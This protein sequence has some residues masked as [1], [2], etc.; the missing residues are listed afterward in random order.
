M[1]NVKKCIRRIRLPRTICFAIRELT[2]ARISNP[3]IGIIIL[4]LHKLR[5]I[6]VIAI[7]TW[8]LFHIN[9]RD[10]SCANVY[11]RSHPTAAENFAMTICVIPI[12]A[13]SNI[14]RINTYVISIKP[15]DQIHIH[16]FFY[17]VGLVVVNNTCEALPPTSHISFKNLNSSHKAKSHL[18]KKT[19]WTIPLQLLLLENDLNQ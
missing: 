11:L 12:R 8:I 5:M 1:L 3:G 6:S 7:R 4:C 9:A 15:A 14:T 13:K 17:P 2:W 10:L 19:R 16:I 18:L